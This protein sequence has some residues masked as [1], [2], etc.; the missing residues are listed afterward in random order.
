MS[1]Q[2]NGGF[3]GDNDY[4][5]IGTD[6][7]R[8][9]DGDTA[10]AA[11]KKFNDHRHTAAIKSNPE[12]LNNWVN[13]LE[14]VSE[15]PTTSRPG[16]YITSSNQALRR[17]GDLADHNGHLYATT[18]AGAKCVTSGFG[19]HID[20][21]GAV[22]AISPDHVAATYAFNTE[23]YSPLGAATFEAALRLG[24]VVVYKTISAHVGAVETRTIIAAGL[25]LSEEFPFADYDNIK[26]ALSVSVFTHRH[27][28]DPNTG[29]ID[30][31][32]PAIDPPVTIASYAAAQNTANVVTAPTG[33][34]VREVSNVTGNFVG[35]IDVMY[36]L[37][38]DGCY[39]VAETATILAETL[40]TEAE[41]NTRLT[42]D[43]E[44]IVKF[45]TIDLSTHVFCTF[46]G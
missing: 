25:R 3:I 4:W 31:G 34:T 19:P 7:E 22:P 10:R 30:V 43:L 14:D 11:A 9:R 15:A 8:G 5:D 29:L 2:H 39:T 40:E 23:S 41:F 46:G 32:N 13:E 20:T 1:R 12:S 17:S 42:T 35:K 6:A 21:T 44:R 28:Y 18:V 24:H 27:P 26:P 45:D 38:V 33:Y 36:M 37:N 16:G